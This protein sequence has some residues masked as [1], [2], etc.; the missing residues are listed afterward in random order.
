MSAKISHPRHPPERQPTCLSTKP[1]VSGAHSPL[2]PLDSPHFE[3]FP[4]LRLEIVSQLDPVHAS[5]STGMIASSSEIDA[6]RLVQALDQLTHNLIPYLGCTP[7]ESP[8]SKL[9]LLILHGTHFLISWP[10]RGWKATIGTSK[11]LL[12]NRDVIFLWGIP[13]ILYY[14][15][16]CT[17]TRRSLTRRQFQG[18]AVVSPQAASFAR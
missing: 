15:S 4:S 5:K 16:N 8:K 9:L 1:M 3:R 14:T 17:R 18:S 12:R 2:T 13:V 11:A 6:P 10:G 7:A